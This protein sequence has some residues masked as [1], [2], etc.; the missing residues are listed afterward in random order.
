MQKATKFTVSMTSRKSVC[1]TAR[2]KNSSINLLHFTNF[3][4]QKK[5]CVNA[6]LRVSV[7]VVG[8]VFFFF[9]TSPITS[10]LQRWKYSQP[11]ETKEFSTSTW[12]WML[13]AMHLILRHLNSSFFSSF[14]FASLFKILSDHLRQND[15]C[16]DSVPDRLA[17]EKMQ[18]SCTWKCEVQGC[19][20][21]RTVPRVGWI[22][23]IFLHQESCHS[24]QVD[25]L[26]F[27]SMQ[28]SPP[29][30]CNLIQNDHVKSSINVKIK[31]EFVF[32]HGDN[33]FFSLL[34]YSIFDFNVFD[35][36]LCSSSI[37]ASSRSL[38]TAFSCI[39]SKVL[40]LLPHMRLV[41]MISDT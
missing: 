22:E 5:S 13:F 32:T 16:L 26:Q 35:V 31:T 29:Q 19:R 27:S 17:M 28:S 18:F 33:I 36:S 10:T 20:L 7:S 11:V 4:G 8:C 25:K 24:T 34:I 37:T 15:D 2:R 14:Q 12:L 23:A 9:C 41:S 30:K 1:N 3:Y 40:L 39:Y 21:E 38:R 6:F